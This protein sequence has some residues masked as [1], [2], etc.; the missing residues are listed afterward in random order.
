MYIEKFHNI[1][2]IKENNYNCISVLYRKNGNM[3][4]ASL[5]LKEDLYFLILYFKN[6]FEIV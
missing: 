3:E 4:D 1:F 2:C 6:Y 5:S